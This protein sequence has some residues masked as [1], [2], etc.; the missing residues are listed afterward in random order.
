VQPK[1]ET[2]DEVKLKTEKTDSKDLVKTEAS[3]SATTPTKRPALSTIDSSRT[4]PR[5]AKS[6]GSKISARDND[7][8]DV[9][10]KCAVMI[11]DA[12]AGDST[13]GELGYVKMVT[14]RL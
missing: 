9:R 13:A 11:Y 8:E 3:S 12:L 14:K 2:K 5:T 1:S 10:D 6:D 7:G 4:V